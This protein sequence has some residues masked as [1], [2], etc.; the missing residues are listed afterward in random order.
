MLVVV[1]VVVSPATGGLAD[2]LLPDDGLDGGLPAGPSCGEFPF[3]VLWGEP[4][5]SNTGSRRRRIE[6]MS[7]YCKIN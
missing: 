2:G 1:V 5:S 6:C 3:G 4:G 7:L